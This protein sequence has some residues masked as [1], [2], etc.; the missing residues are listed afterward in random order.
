MASHV[1]QPLWLHETLDRPLELQPQRFGQRFPS[2]PVSADEVQ[3]RR[4]GVWEQMLA[5]AL[6]LVDQGSRLLL[7]Q[8]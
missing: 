5:P 2:T 4:G 1:E 3:R 6:L 8:M 7:G